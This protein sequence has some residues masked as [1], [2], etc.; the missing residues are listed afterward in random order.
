MRVTL[1]EWSRPRKVTMYGRKVLYNHV[2]DGRSYKVVNPL[3]RCIN[4][5]DVCSEGRRSNYKWWGWGLKCR[6]PPTLGNILV[7][8]RSTQI[9]HTHTYTHKLPINNWIKLSEYRNKISCSLKKSTIYRIISLALC[10]LRN[11]YCLL[12][13]DLSRI[14]QCRKYLYMNQLLCRR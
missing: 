4:A 1:L 10:I 9:P 3:T 14:K 13:I 12:F 2:L 11:V 6:Q 5:T 8:T 7:P